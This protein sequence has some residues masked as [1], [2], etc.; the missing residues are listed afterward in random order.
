MKD[1]AEQIKKEL[2]AIAQHLTKGQQ[3]GNILSST[4][5][6]IENITDVHE[7]TNEQL[8][9]IVDRIEVDSDG[10]VDIF[11][12]IFGELGL[13]NT[14]LISDTYTQRPVRKTTKNRPY[15]LLAGQR[16]IRI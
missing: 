13:K 6:S 1:E 4:F 7:M 12:R 3:L 8:K 10:N 9:R 2:N 14:V 16:D 5:K 11:L 15:S